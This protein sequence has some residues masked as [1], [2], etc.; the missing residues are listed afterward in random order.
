M[1]AVLSGMV[2]KKDCPNR[3]DVNISEECDSR[4]VLSWIVLLPVCDI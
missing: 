4:M 2:E 1:T 3:P